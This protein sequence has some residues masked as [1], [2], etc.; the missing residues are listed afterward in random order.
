MSKLQKARS[1]LA[2]FLSRYILLYSG[3]TVLLLIAG[4][5]ISIK[6]FPE[7]ALAG[8]VMITIATI[9]QALSDF[10]QNLISA[11]QERQEK[12]RDEEQS[13]LIDRLDEEQ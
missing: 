6:V 12:E 4:G 10:A 5:L 13:E 8:Y 11:E 2:Q 1:V 7:A 3:F 9:S